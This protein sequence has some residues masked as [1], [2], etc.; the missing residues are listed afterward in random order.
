MRINLA[1]D[2]KQAIFNALNRFYDEI[3]DEPLSQYQAE[4]LLEFFVV[5]LGHSF[6]N[7]GVQDARAFIFDKLEDLDAEFYEPE[8]PV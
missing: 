2:R 8:E 4:R 6:Y 1:D 7:Q 3:F 5:T